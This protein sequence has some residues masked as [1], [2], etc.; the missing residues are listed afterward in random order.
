MIYL[1]PVVAYLLGSVSS[2][3]VIARVMGLQDP[4][5]VGSGNPGATNVLRYGGKL[6]AILTLVGDVLKGVLAVLIA[7]YFTD[8]PLILAT[9]ALAAF[10]GHLFPL[11][12]GFKGGKGVA[13]ALGVWLALN[14]WVGL[15]LVGAWLLTAIITR[16][17]SL[18]AVVASVA[19]PFFV[20]W[21]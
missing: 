1:L 11:F 8:D 10:L 3:I 18:S 14:P 20:A 16:Y 19:A 15:L 9:T 4:R 7:R 21:L 13:T 5:E 2:A 6:A 12:H 17:S